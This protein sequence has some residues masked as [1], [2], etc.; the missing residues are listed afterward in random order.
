MRNNLEKKRV[1]Y[2]GDKITNMQQII[3]NKL[4]AE[5]YQSEM[6]ID[7]YISQVAL[8]LQ[9]IRTTLIGSDEYKCKAI[10]LALEFNIELMASYIL[11]DDEVYN[12]KYEPFF[13]NY[14]K[15]LR[16]GNLN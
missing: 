1:F 16:P 9:L 11:A 13:E 14:N 15:Y 6:N 12:Y 10:H 7:D 4:Y 3:V 2:F 8:G 5:K